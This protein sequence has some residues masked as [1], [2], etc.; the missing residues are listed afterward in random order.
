MTYN[1]RVHRSTLQR[2]RCSNI[3]HSVCMWFVLGELHCPTFGPQSWVT[4]LEDLRQCPL[5]FHR[6][7]GIMVHKDETSP[8]VALMMSS[9]LHGKCCCW[10][11][12]WIASATRNGSGKSTAISRRE[13]RHEGFCGDYERLGLFSE[14]ATIK[15]LGPSSSYFSVSTNKKRF[16]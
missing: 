11:R 4:I 1:N 14:Q 9:F 13:P 12:I 6:N 10:Q 5:G 15:F 8:K 3:V 2:T 16:C 7:L